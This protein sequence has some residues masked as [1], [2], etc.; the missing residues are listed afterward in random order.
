MFLVCTRG[1]F[2]PGC[3]CSGLVEN[4]CSCGKKILLVLLLFMGKMIRVRVKEILYRWY[5]V[6]FGFLKRS[7]I[8]L[9]SLLRLG[10]LSILVMY[11]VC[12]STLCCSSQLI[13]GYNP[14]GMNS[15]SVWFYHLI[16]VFVCL[17][18]RRN[19]YTNAI[20]QCLVDCILCSACHLQ[21]V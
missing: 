4:T 20:V 14:L 2:V 5:W 13:D 1:T 7:R 17:H 9:T 19:C 21:W 12:L 18:L 16:C 15:L 11:S 6:V 10:Q 3:L 8:R